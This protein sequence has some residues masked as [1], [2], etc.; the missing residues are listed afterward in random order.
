[1]TIQQ[2]LMST[3]IASQTYWTNTITNGTSSDVTIYG[4]AFDSEGN[5]YVCGRSVI[6]GGMTDGF[7]YKLNKAGTLSKSVHLDDPNKG[8]T[9][10]AIVIDSSD[11]V[12]VYA[13]YGT[14]VKYNSNLEL[15]YYKK[16]NWS[17]G[18]EFDE[19]SSISNGHCMIFAGGGQM[20]QVAGRQSGGTLGLY[21]MFY[22]ATGIIDNKWYAYLN[23]GTVAY[24]GGGIVNGQIHLCGYDIN[25]TYTNGNAYWVVD[26]NGVGN[27]YRFYQSGT[28]GAARCIVRDPNGSIYIGGNMGG[29][30]MITKVASYNETN[31]NQGTAW[32]RR[33]NNPGPA[34]NDLALD[35]Q[36][37]VYGVTGTY[38]GA[39]GWLIKMDSNGNILWSR[40]F[41]ANDSINKITID[42]DD[43]IWL[44]IN[45]NQSNNPGVSIIARLTSDG[46]GAGSVSYTHLTLPTSDLV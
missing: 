40:Q 44:T 30:P 15:Q 9:F 45:R 34:Y 36:G 33:G 42:S 1:M 2:M 17:N 10:S 22:T 26:I 37:N 29:Y 43:N 19:G 38:N 32:W 20:L 5:F 39:S 4:H 27:T 18:T 8:I 16:N 6:S 21:A 41:N 28:S 35:S 14:I 11:N 13:G 3:G 46:H 23:S 7:I 31:T 12:Y 25:P 24:Q